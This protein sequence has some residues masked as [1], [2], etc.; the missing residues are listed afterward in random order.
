MAVNPIIEC[1]WRDLVPEYCQGLESSTVCTG[2]RSFVESVLGHSNMSLHRLLLDMHAEDIIPTFLTSNIYIE[3]CLPKV[4]ALTRLRSY[5]MF[6]DFLIVRINKSVGHRGIL[7]IYL[8]RDTFPYRL[9][10]GIPLK[11]GVPYTLQS[12]VRTP[13]PHHRWTILVL[14]ISLNAWLPPRPWH[15]DE[16]WLLRPPCRVQT[17]VTHQLPA[18]WYRQTQRVALHPAPHRALLALP[19]LSAGLKTCLPPSRIQKPAR[20]L[21]ILCQRNLPKRIRDGGSG[22]CNDRRCL[23]LDHWSPAVAASIDLVTQTCRIL[24][25][26]RAD[27]WS[28]TSGTDGCLWVQATWRW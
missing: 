26:Q 6:E 25:L 9:A 10:R 7:N 28:S 8:V 23:H 16:Q 1:F 24:Y 17:V 3:K 12:K 21:H 13:P 11:E 19:L 27:S 5:E 22:N 15:S 20:S 14:Q 2:P 18:E 4:L